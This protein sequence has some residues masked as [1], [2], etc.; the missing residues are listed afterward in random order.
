MNT[1]TVPTP[2]PAKSALDGDPRILILHAE[3]AERLGISRWQAYKLARSGR[4][5]TTRLGARALHGPERQ[6]V[7]ELGIRRGALDTNVLPVGVE[8]FGDD[9]GEACVNALP[10]LQVLGEYGHGVVNAD[11]HER[12][13]FQRRASCAF[14]ALSRR[15]RAAR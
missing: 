7:V 5:A 4:V 10:H 2:A 14:G 1:Y 6:V 8:L 9:S 15:A 3:A 13:R 11:T 12:V